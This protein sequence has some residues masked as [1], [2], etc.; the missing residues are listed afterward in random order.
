MNPPSFSYE[1]WAA[2]H[3]GKVREI[4][5]DGYLVEPASGLWLVADGMGGYD[6][7]EVASGAIVAHLATLGRPSSA[8]DQH[9]RFLVRLNKAIREVQDYSYA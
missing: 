6:A 7:G 5:E 4:N 2:T 8:Q 3:P 1:S 9:A